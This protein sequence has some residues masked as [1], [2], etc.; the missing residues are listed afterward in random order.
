MLTWQ[1]DDPTDIAAANKYTFYKPSLEVLSKVS[2]GEV[3]KLMFRGHSDHD[4]GVYVE[5]RGG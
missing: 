5:R 1:L 3:V 2:I 4:D